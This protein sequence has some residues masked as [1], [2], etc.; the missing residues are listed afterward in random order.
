MGWNFDMDEKRQV[1]KELFEDFVS[2]EKKNRPGDLFQ[3]KPKVSISLCF[4]HLVIIFIVFIITLAVVFSIGV[5]KGK[6]VAPP[7]VSHAP[8]DSHA[9]KFEIEESG[10][11]VLNQQDT[12]DNTTV[13]SKPVEVEAPFSFTVQVASYLREDT[14]K[15][16]AEQLK[17]QGNDAFVLKKG[18]YYITCVGKFTDRQSAD[19]Q[20][21]KLRKTY[22]DC[23]VRKI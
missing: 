14:A 20:M 5:E 9:R 19:S 15:R 12:G 8:E 11:V 3:K 18:D 2:R 4:E 1:Q 7:L 16:H 23:L 22:S 17:A 10:H 21:R 13:S 6:S